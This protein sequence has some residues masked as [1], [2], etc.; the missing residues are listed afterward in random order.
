[1]IE[2]D[3]R[4]RAVRDVSREAAEQLRSLALAIDADP[5]AMEAHL[6]TEVYAMVRT[7]NTPAKHRESLPGRP[8]RLLD[9]GNC[10]ETVVGTL[11]LARG[12]AGALLACPSPALAGVIVDLLGD[13][14]Q[15]ELFY[16]RLHGGRTWT[17]FAMTEPG[18]GSD[19]TAMETRLEAD[20][21]GGWLLRGEK[22]YIGNGARGGVGVVFARTGRSALSIRAVLVEPPHEA[23]HAQR[24][25]M[26]G[27]RGAALSALRFDGMP[28]RGDMLLGEHLPVT[29]RGIWGAIETFNN[30]RIQ[31]AAL[32]VGTALAIA[33]YVAE[34]RK[35][36][37]GL[38]VALTRAEAARE[39]VYQA[40][41]RVLRDPD[42]SYL[43]CA[44]KLGA[45]RMAVQTARWAS[46]AMGPAGLLEHPLLEKWTRDVCAFEFMEGT[47]DIQRL[48]VA[49]GYL[50]GDADG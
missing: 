24:L 35:S 27:L 19:A 25:D 36:A 11:E 6:D 43:S 23:W 48:H 46:G 50:S 5:D 30:M 10:L 45:T 26:V 47:G 38:P 49:K 20:G 17:F 21:A 41:A 28:V 12:D 34:H 16:T 39:L 31:V 14:R 9:E 3:A 1:M 33:E 13:E 2:L 32:A 40:A 4:L 29:R 37:P 18:R 8:L 7:S 44:A 15:R 42:N 22:R